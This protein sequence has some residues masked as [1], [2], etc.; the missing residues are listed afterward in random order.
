MDSLP[1]PLVQWADA[2]D[3]AADQP[4]VPG[5]PQP[6]TYYLDMSLDHPR[7]AAGDYLMI[8]SGATEPAPEWCEAWSEIGRGFWLYRRLATRL[9]RPWG[10]WH[11]LGL[12]D[13]A[14]AA[15]R[16]VECET[17]AILVIVPVQMPSWARGARAFNFE[18]RAR[19]YV[20]P[21]P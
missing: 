6:R 9:A 20:A 19:S 13:A 15:K 1:A 17:G 3:G 18:L 4:I 14:D 11:A 10:P 21:Y 2:A 7:P 5:N 12:F 8:W 16:L